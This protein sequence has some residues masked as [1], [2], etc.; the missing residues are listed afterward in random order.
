MKK[1]YV[2]FSNTYQQNVHKHL[3]Y[4]YIYAPFSQIGQNNASLDPKKLMLQYWT[5]Q[6]I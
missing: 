5:K 6:L 4:I 3:E 1:C 2:Y